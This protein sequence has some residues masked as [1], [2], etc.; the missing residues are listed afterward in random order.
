MGS[1]PLKRVAIKNSDIEV[2]EMFIDSKILKRSSLKDSRLS[3]Y[4]RVESSF[5]AER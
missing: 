5:A 4:K 1:I 3:R 2:G